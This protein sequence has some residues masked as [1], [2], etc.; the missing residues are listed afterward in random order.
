VAGALAAG[1]WAAL[2]SKGAAAR[3]ASSPGPSCANCRQCWTLGRPYPAGMTISAGRWPVLLRR[4][5]PGSGW[6][7]VCPGQT[8]CTGSVERAVPAR[9]AAERDEAPITTWREDRRPVVKGQ[10][11]TM[12]GTLFLGRQ[13]SALSGGSV[14]ASRRPVVPRRRVR[15]VSSVSTAASYGDAW[16]VRGRSFS[17]DRTGFGEHH[18]SRPSTRGCAPRVRDLHHENDN[19]VAEAPAG[20]REGGET[21]GLRHGYRRQVE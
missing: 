9:Q 17:K 2:A 1:G 11:R 12:V 8:C 16:N 13:G 7:T 19:I 10:R 5:G 21:D 18:G 20:E 6:A 3:S 4:S 14:P 15:V